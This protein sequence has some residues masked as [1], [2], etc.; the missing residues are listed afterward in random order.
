M[1]LRGV[2]LC[3]VDVVLPEEDFLDLDEEAEEEGLLERFLV[4]LEEPL[5]DFGA[6]CCRCSRM[7]W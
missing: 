2:G 3:W 1:M 6:I 7:S 5:L 4:A